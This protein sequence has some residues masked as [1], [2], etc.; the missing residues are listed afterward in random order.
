LAPFIRGL[1]PL[2][3]SLAVYLLGAAIVTTAFLGWRRNVRKAG[4]EA[5]KKEMQERVYAQVNKANKAA[6]DAAGVPVDEWLREHK[7]LRE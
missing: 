3:N 2:W 1:L 4:Q 7:L 6:A 5:V